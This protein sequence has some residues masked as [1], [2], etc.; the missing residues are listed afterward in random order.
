MRQLSRWPYFRHVTISGDLQTDVSN[1][2]AANG[3]QDTAIHCAAVA[4]VS[5]EL[6][7]R[8]GLDEAL[9]TSS[10]LLHDMADVMA[11]QDM[12]TYAIDNHW[13]L[14]VAEKQY[15]F[16]L[17][18]RLSA[19]LA[20]ELFGIDNPVILS[21]IECHTTLKASPSDYD[22]L[23]FLA[24]KLAWG[25]AGMPPF[26]GLVASALDHSLKHAALVYINFVLDKGMILSPHNWLLEAR[27][28]L[29]DYVSGH[30]RESF[31]T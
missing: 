7:A 3:K 21:A 24:D 28:W 2:L 12:L 26:H 22:L 13:L 30:T 1:F 5:Q 18:Q 10:A 29:K 6:A 25:Q 16:L 27:N 20:R 8:F 17:H 11:P 9:A 23:L 19:V 14:H 31:R 4:K 15:P